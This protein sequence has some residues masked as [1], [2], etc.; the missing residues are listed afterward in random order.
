M[1]FVK[2]ASLRRM[3][4]VR[5]PRKNLFTDFIKAIDFFAPQVHVTARYDDDDRRTSCIRA[6]AAA[7]IAIGIINYQ[8]A[9][10]PGKAIDQWEKRFNEKEKYN[11][12]PGY[13]PQ[14]R[15]NLH[16]GYNSSCS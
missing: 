16:F 8:A 11:R 9:C 13:V 5:R 1:H 12:Y 10:L 14:C 3:K 4:M 7:Q 15:K 2:I 6:W